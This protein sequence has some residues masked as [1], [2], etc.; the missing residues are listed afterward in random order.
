[1]V[2]NSHVIR[3]WA[4]YSLPEFR[5]KWSGG[6]LRNQKTK[7]YSW[8]VAY[9]A[10][11]RQVLW[12]DTKF[13]REWTRQVEQVPNL[14]RAYTI[15]IETNEHNSP[16][17]MEIWKNENVTIWRLVVEVEVENRTIWYQVCRF[18]GNCG[19]VSMMMTGRGGDFLPTWFLNYFIIL[20]PI[21]QLG[22]FLLIA[23]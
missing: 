14:T 20:L 23:L 7:T 21:F 3:G 15:Q 1:M 9:N 19:H 18:K 16:Q 2:P 12:M 5:L 4:P 11:R 8:P 22:N 17:V 6:L 13:L 10:R